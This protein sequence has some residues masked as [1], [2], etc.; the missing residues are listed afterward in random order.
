MESILR[1]I[2]VCF[3]YVVLQIMIFCA[4]VHASDIVEYGSVYTAGDA[5]VPTSEQMAI[6]T[7]SGDSSADSVEIL[8]G[9]SE[10]IDTLIIVVIMLFGIWLVVSFM[11]NIF[12]K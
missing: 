12:R 5:V 3:V 6:S 9:I 1:K 4:D 2:A 10:K 11:R 8:K 7:T